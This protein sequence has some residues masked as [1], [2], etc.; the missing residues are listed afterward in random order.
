MRKLGCVLMMTILLLS[1]C[2]G[3]GI[4][5][6]EQA[7]LDIRAKYLAMTGCTA[8][9]DITADY[10]ERIFEC[11]LSLDHTAGGETVLTVQEP[12]ILQGV[13]ARLKD[14]ESMLEFDGVRLETGEL[15]STGLSPID[16]VPYLLEQI[17]GGFISTWG[18]EMLEE[19]ECVRFTTSD[20]NN[21]LGVGQETSLWF[22]RESF[23]LV[24]GEIAVD[25]TMVLNCWV[26]DFMWK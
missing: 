23:A 5:E 11:V 9:L 4:D 12:E 21:T 17:S 1:G 18:I 26:R 19:R 25:G 24:Y 2:G 14:G 10:G 6:A 7:A 16:C 3:G 20:P 8:T 15:S 13:T 22:D